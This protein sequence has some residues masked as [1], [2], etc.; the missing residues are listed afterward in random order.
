M[1]VSSSSANDSF[2]RRRAGVRLLSCLLLLAASIAANAQDDATSGEFTIQSAYTQMLDGV[3]HVSA[4]INYG[5][6]RSAI[7][8]LNNGVDLTFE[9]DIEVKRKRRW[10]PDKTEHELRQ[11]YELSFD[12]LTQRYVVR[13]LNSGEQT[14]FDTLSAALRGLGDVDRVPV[15]DAALLKAERDYRIAVRTSLDTKSF[16]GPLRLL[17][18]LF[19]FGEWRLASS[20]HSWALN[21]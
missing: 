10:L 12:A 18:S 7:D 21:P 3:Y 2:G 8:A 15:I 4:Q 9:L 11:R 13:L 14:S 1:H 6:T 19:K 5:L 20:W 17:A 16:R